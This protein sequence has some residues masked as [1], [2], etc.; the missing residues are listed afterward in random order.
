MTDF[1]RHH[2]G[3]HT[4]MP[5]WLL[6]DYSDTHEHL[7]S[8]MKKNPSQKPLCYDRSTFVDGSLCLFFS[9]DGKFQPMPWDFYLQCYF[10][11]LPHLL[12]SKITCLACGLAC[13]KTNTGGTVYLRNHGWPKA[14]R[15]V[16]DLKQCLFIIGYCYSCGNDLCKKTY[17]SWSPAILTTL[18]CAL[19]AQFTHYHSG[20]T[21]HVVAVPFANMIHT[22][23]ICYY[24]Q[25]HLQDLK[26]I[27]ACLHSPFSFM[28]KYEPFGL[29]GDWDGYAGFTPSPKYFCQLYVNLLTV[30]AP[31]I[32]QY[33]AIYLQGFWI[34]ITA[35]R[36]L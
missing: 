28:V 15:W 20:L 6:N 10:V 36:Y 33:T 5:N 16:V 23:H 13:K 17:Q 29:F 25:L 31:E 4:V 19:A 18:P 34:L 8:E 12:V 35:L 26:M 1:N 9:A 7:Q 21:D 3:E 11:W 2:A 32:E 30:H 14:S 22:N 27:Y 24:K